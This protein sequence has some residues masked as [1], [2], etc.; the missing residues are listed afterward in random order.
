MFQQNPRVLFRN[1]DGTYIYS[2]RAV[3]GE[4]AAA[5]RRFFCNALPG[6]ACRR[7]NDHPPLP[8][9]LNNTS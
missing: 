6:Q 2:G 9:D 3:S 5:I 8:A 4:N 7:W 1:M